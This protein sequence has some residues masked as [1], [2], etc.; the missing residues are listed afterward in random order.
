[1]RERERANR[2]HCPYQHVAEV[3]TIPFPDAFRLDPGDTWARL[4]DEA[5]LTRVRTPAGDLVWL[6]TRYDDVRTVLTDPRFSRAGTVA[7]GAP[8]VAVSSPLPGTLPTT[9]PPEHTRLRRLVSAAF[10][11]RRVETYRPWIRELAVELADGLGAAGAPADLRA[12]L[13]LPL[14]IRVICRLLGVPYRRE[15]LN[16]VYAD[17]DRFREWTELAYSM[18]PA[19]AARVHAAMDALTG[20]L[21]GL[22]AAKRAE[23][24][25]DILSELAA[26][27][28]GLSPDELTAFGLNLLVAGHETSANQITGF[29]ATLLRDPAR[30]DR[31]V[32]E[33]DLVPTAVEELLR[34]TRLSETGQLRVAVEDVALAGGTVRA[35]EG[36]MAAIASANRDPRAF[37]R[38]DEVVL[39]REP[40]R[41]LAFGV[42]THFCL[43]AHLARVE[44]Q[45]TLS[46][47]LARFPGL[48]LAVPAEALVWRHVLV[49]GV[50]ALPVR[51]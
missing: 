10:A 30:W 2:Q 19:E 43:G 4:R 37:D 32:A 28:A 16:S 7:P 51:W 49:S 5:P 17:R 9:D 36:V 38:P 41:H 39:D 31:L 35:G 42:G 46:A 48:R 23:P 47:L 44:L 26:D 24:G 11:Y 13:G 21:A 29:V 14:P 1:M 6:V 25:D 3:P 33:P 20:Y 15:L 27:P 50:D 12:G 45:E 8:R 34:H 22:V 40:G 18:V